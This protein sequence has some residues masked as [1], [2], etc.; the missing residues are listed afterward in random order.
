[1]KPEWGQKRICK[2]CKTTFY[3]MKKNPIVC[4]KCQTSFTIEEL[5]PRY[6]RP[7]VEDASKNKIEVEV[8]DFDTADDAGLP[9]NGDIDDAADISEENIST[10]K[11]SEAS[12]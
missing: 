10:E 2:K 4:P 7:T 12:E 3:D 11:D 1:M 5:V 9:D 6:M 8:E